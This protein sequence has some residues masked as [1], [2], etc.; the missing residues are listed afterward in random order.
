MKEKP[1]VTST[2]RTGEVTFLLQDLTNEIQ[3]I[4]VAEKENRISQG[5]NYSEFI[6]KEVQ[7]D[8]KQISLFNEVF[9]LEKKNFGRQIG[10]LSEKIYAQK[11]DEVVIVSLARAGTPIGILVKKYLERHYR[12]NI[13]HYSISIIRG[14][15]IDMNA[16]NT[17]VLKHGSQSIQFIDGWT[18]KGSIINELENS[19]VKFNKRYGQAVK[20]DLAVVAD[21]AKRCTIYATR[22]DAFIPNCWFNATISGLISRTVHQQTF[23]SE[24]YHGASFLKYL[25]AVDMSQ[26][27]IDEVAEQLGKQQIGDESEKV[28]VIYAMN[29]IE[30]I[31]KKYCV[32]D[33]HKI[34]I[35]I[36]ETLRVLLRRQPKVVLVKSGYSPVVER[37]LA[38]AYNR[39]IPIMYDVP[40]L[41]NYEI[42]I[43]IDG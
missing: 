21:P 2:Y 11:G 38:L 22:Q 1:L 39:K 20:S 17:I 5:Q 36:G 27:F 34:K 32:E 6:S 25:E 42:G 26:Q 15:G 19:I 3:E 35:G 41:E 4:T 16:L 23:E 40:E 12:V 43:I 37:V 29:I 24:A 10:I 14:K 9:A 7:P 33:F 8:S 13:P 30:E 18:G 28:D 31:Q